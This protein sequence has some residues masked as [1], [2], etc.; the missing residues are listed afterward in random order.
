MV[1]V[2]VPQVVAQVIDV[3][4]ISCRTR[5]LLSRRS[6]RSPRCRSWS[7]RNK[8]QQRTVQ[9][10]VALRVPQV[11]WTVRSNLPDTKKA[12]REETQELHIFRN[13]K[14]NE[15][16][17]EGS[18]WRE[19]VGCVKALDRKKVKPVTKEDLDPGDEHEKKVLQEW[20]QQRTVEQKVDLPVL[21][22]AGKMGKAV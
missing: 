5:S 15:K 19:H 10:L 21:Q 16:K 7:L 14:V 9:Q 22:V 3:V 18:S 4:K 12:A 11:G 2:L 17:C 20:A 6:K 13:S 8:V 1:D